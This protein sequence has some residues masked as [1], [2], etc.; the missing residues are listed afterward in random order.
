MTDRALI[1]LEDGTVLHGT[2]FGARST[3]TGE[4]CFNT[5]MTGYQEILTDPS[6]HGQIVTLTTAHVGNTGTNSFD[7]Q[8][9][10]P[11]VAGFVI[12]DASRVHSSWRAD[13]SL[14]SY[15]ARHDI[16]AI[17]DVDTRRLTRHIRTAGAMRG[18]V[19]SIVT[20]PDELVDIARAA[21]G[22]VG[23]DLAREVST[24]EPYTWDSTGLDRGRSLLSLVRPRT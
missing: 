19:S 20:D 16:T 5:G 9:R 17:A 4:V 6:Y 11:W 3:T 21:P 1:A 24:S 15:L 2:A 14:D 22:L 18:A 13:A 7:D 10:R 8:S 12:H 23:R